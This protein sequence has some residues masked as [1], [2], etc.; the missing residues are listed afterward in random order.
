M[1][2]PIQLIRNYFSELDNNFQTYLL[3]KRVSTGLIVNRN[4]AKKMTNFKH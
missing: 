2:I 1:Q 4:T 3:T